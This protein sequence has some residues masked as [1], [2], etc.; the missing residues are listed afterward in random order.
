MAN[1]PHLCTVGR[2]R[3]RSFNEVSIPKTGQPPN[4]TGGCPRNHI[5]IVNI[6]ATVLHADGQRDSVG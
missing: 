1:N 6:K 3:L 2:I 5:F 4:K